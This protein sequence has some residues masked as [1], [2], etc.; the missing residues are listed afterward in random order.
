M[1]IWYHLLPMIFYHMMSQ[2]YFMTSYFWSHSKLS[3]LSL[4]HSSNFHYMGRCVGDTICRTTNSW[5]ALFQSCL[6]FPSSRCWYQLCNPSDRA[7]SL[8]ILCICQKV[9]LYLSKSDFVFGRGWFFSWQRWI[10]LIFKKY[11]LKLFNITSII[12]ASK[13]NLFFESN[14]PFHTLT[15]F[16]SS[17]SS[18][19]S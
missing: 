15:F 10:F 6:G 2:K 9:I 14:K 3:F 13:N 7:R 1:I 4:Y 5:F 8:K 18:T 19:K 16:N 12:S 17:G 11:I